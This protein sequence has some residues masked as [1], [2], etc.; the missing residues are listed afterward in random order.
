MG[1]TGLFGLEVG[2]KIPLGSWKPQACYSFGCPPVIYPRAP[3]KK[4]AHSFGARSF[5]VW[6]VEARE[7]MGFFTHC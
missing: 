3:Q 1:G 4:L 6:R 5:L 7:D 2:R